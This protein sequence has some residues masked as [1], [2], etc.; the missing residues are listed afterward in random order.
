MV[1]SFEED[2]E[3]VERGGQQVGQ[4]DHDE[5]ARDLAQQQISEA[6]PEEADDHT[7]VGVA[8]DLKEGVHHG[9]DTT[10]QTSRFKHPGVLRPAGTR[11]PPV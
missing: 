8:P 11:G 6:Q 7:D 3:R 4:P 9:L 1:L 5:H 2:H 10:V